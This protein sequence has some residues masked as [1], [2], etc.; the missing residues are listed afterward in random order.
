MC[1]DEIVLARGQTVTALSIASLWQAPNRS[2]ELRLA[3]RIALRLTKDGARVRERKSV[4][5]RDLVAALLGRMKPRE[6]ASALAGLET[7]AQAAMNF[8]E[9]RKFKELTR[10]TA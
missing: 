3:R 8:I 5:D 1:L 10:R 9:S 6:R 7:L 4:L 2:L